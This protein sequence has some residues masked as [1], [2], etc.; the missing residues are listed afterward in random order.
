[1]QALQCMR[2]EGPRVKILQCKSMD[3][4]LKEKEEG[5]LLVWLQGAITAY[6]P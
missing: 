4:N 3:D 6:E 2:L 1:M 5:F